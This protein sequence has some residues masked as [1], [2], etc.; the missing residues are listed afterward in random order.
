VL[1]HTDRDHDGALPYVIERY[2]P[3]V[4]AGALPAPCAE[5]LPRATLVFDIATGRAEIPVP[6]GGRRLSR[7]VLVRGGEQPG[8]EGSRSLWIHDA[9]GA[10]LLCG[11]A[12]AAGLAG[13]LSELR[14]SGALR[15]LLFPHHGSQTELV[16]PLLA[17]LTPAEIWISCSGDPPILPELERRGVRWRTTERDGPLVLERKIAAA[18]TEAP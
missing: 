6:S 9:E 12:N 7:V 3:S 18:R 1:S 8:N 14:G 11:D 4:W 15:L 16:S 13:T 17:A 2:P 5:R 10:L